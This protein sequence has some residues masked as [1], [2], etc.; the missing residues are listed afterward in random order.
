MTGQRV[1]QLNIVVFNQIEDSCVAAIAAVSPYLQ[2][3]IGAPTAQL[4]KAQLRNILYPPADINEL[5]GEAEVL[6]TFKPPD[7][8]LARAPKLKWIQF[9][10]AGVDQV[11]DLGLDSTDIILTTTSGMHAGPMSEFVLGTMLMFAHWFPRAL[12][13][14]LAHQWKRFAAGELAG[15]TVGI[16]GYGHI[17]KAVAR[18]QPSAAFQPQAKPMRKAKPCTCFPRTASL[19]CWSGAI[20]WLWRY[21]W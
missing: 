9:F 10:S 8:L 5:L 20:L 3:R 1:T 14:Q 7:N 4:P 2:V 19:I 11:A 16:V 21:P 12:R 15:K 17:G 6:F 18:S 13:Q